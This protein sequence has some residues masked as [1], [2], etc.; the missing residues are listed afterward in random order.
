MAACKA[1][2]IIWGCGSW[3][4]CLNSLGLNFPNYRPGRKPRSSLRA[5]SATGASK[6]AISSIHQVCRASSDTSF[7]LILCL[8][9]LACGTDLRVNEIM[10]VKDLCKPAVPNIFG[11]KYRF[12]GRRF[13]HRGRGDSGGNASDGERQ[14]QLRSSPPLTSCCAALFLTDRGWL[15]GWGYLL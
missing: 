12:R 7:L 15:R 10:Q 8:L 11:T 4:G 2:L 5:V 6:G 13:F 1:G 9:F 3:S 14:M